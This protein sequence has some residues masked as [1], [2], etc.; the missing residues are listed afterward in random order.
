MWF[1]LKS[2]K[3]AALLCGALLLGDVASAQTVLT[4]AE[5]KGAAKQLLAERQPRAALQLADALLVRDPNDLTAHLVRARALRDLNQFQQAEAT[6][7]TAW[8][9]AKSDGDR[10][11]AAMIRAQVLS[12]AGKRTRAQLW[13]RRA[14]ELAPNDRLKARAARDFGHVRQRNPWSTQLS[15]TLAP[16]SNINN[17]SAQDTSFL[18]YV[19]T[20]IL[21]NGVPVEAELSGSLV[22]LSG[23]EYGIG[24]RTR[25]RFKQNQSSAH[26]LTFGAGYRSYVLSD[27]ARAEAPDVTGSDFAFGTVDLGYRYTKR[28][29]KGRGRL[30]LGAEIGQSWFGGA[31]LSSYT[32]LS[33]TQAVTHSR[34]LQMRYGLNQE[35]QTGQR[36]ND[37]DRTAGTV[38]M[39]KRL[40]GGNLMSLSF[41]VALGQSPTPSAE[42]QSVSLRGGLTLAKP[43]MGA[44]IQFN[45]G[46]EVRDFDV[47]PHGPDGRNDKKLFASVAAT[48]TKIDYFGFNPTATMSF[49]TTDSNVGLYNVD[50]IAVNFGIRSAF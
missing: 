10:F 13:L 2:L 19:Q 30:E 40:E 9:L 4:T 5:M 24:L 34:S 11:A 39:L 27:S 28:N 20:K 26:D 17:G 14:S 1:T 45:L 7:K 8:R 49:S 35:W 41:G 38:T 22:A 48:F 33:Y 50:R 18:N 37:L 44:A 12:S 31:R 46:A 47:T 29:L 15:F 6:A 3:C 42:Y 23:L 25:Y 36:N 21:N 32:G 43:V 16:N